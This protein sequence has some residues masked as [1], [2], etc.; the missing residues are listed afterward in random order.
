MGPDPCAQ[1]KIYLWVWTPLLPRDELRLNKTYTLMM[2]S[3]Y[4]HQ[5]RYDVDRLHTKAS[6]SCAVSEWDI[7]EVQKKSQMTLV[8]IGRLHFSFRWWCNAAVWYRET[9]LKIKAK[10][11]CFPPIK[12]YSPCCVIQLLFEEYPYASR[13][14]VGAAAGTR[15]GGGDVVHAR[16]PPSRE[17]TWAVATAFSGVLCGDGDGIWRWLH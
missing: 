8:S 16:P 7:E 5:T 12:S 4:I 2:N 1:P 9:T 11:I 6:A 10:A 14:T 15:P 13:C 17:G 3:S